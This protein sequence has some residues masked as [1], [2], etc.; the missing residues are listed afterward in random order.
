[1]TRLSTFKFH[2]GNVSKPFAS[3]LRVAQAGRGVGLAP[4]EDKSYIEN[5]ETDECI[6]LREEKGVYVF[7]F[8]DAIG[9]VSVVILDSGPGISVWPDYTLPSVK[10]LPKRA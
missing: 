10:L 5:T 7:V 3:A 9:E 4:G 8:V 2:V 1:M 6:G